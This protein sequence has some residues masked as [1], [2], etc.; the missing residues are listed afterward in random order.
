MKIGEIA[1]CNNCGAENEVPETAIQTDEKRASI[2]KPFP[3]APEEQAYEKAIQKISKNISD[4]TKCPNCAESKISKQTIIIERK[5]RK[6]GHL[7]GGVVLF[8]IGLILAWLYISSLLSPVVLP[9]GV[10]SGYSNPIPAGLMAVFLLTFGIKLIAR[11]FGIVRTT[12]YKCRCDT[13]GHQWEDKESAAIVS[14]VQDLNN[15]DKGVR[16]TAVQALGKTGDVR[17]VEPLIL[18]AHDKSWVVRQTALGEFK[19]IKEQ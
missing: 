10:G 14:L 5:P 16:E 15:E 11:Y 4:Q 17:A 2:S 7:V 1:Q 3:K 18:A 12:L 8:I 6:V 9:A 19:K 13:C